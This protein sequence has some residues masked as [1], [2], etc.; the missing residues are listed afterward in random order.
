M[1]TDSFIKKNKAKNYKNN[2]NDVCVIDVPLIFKNKRH[3]K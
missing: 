1:Y 3:F 2:E